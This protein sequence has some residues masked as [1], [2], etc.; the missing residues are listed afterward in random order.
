MDLKT[1]RRQLEEAAQA[2]QDRPLDLP[3]PPEAPEVSLYRMLIKSALARGKQLPS[4]ASAPMERRER[5]MT[6]FVEDLQAADEWVKAVTSYAIARGG[7]AGQSLMTDIRH[8]AAL[9]EK[10]RAE[11]S[12]ETATTLSEAWTTC[13][14]HLLDSVERVKWVVYRPVRRKQ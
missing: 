5:L 3:T 6:A 1:Y 7:K 11:F 4:F 10:L 12:E 8:H 2:A 14:L 9:L 13:F